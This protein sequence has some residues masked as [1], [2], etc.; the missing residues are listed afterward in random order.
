MSNL[1]YQFLYFRILRSSGP[2]VITV[3]NVKRKLPCVQ[4]CMGVSPNMRF[5][6][7]ISP[8]IYIFFLKQLPLI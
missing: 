4:T 1:F 2:L 7:A 5:E 6:Y 3:C 8:D